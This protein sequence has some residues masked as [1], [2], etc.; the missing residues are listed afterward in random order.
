MN[1]PTTLLISCAILTAVM[2]GSGEPS[3]SAPTTAGTMPKFEDYPVTERLTAKPAEPIFASPET[4]RYLTR[5][6]NGVSTGVGVWNGSWKDPIIKTSGP[7]FAGHYFV[8]RWGCGAECVTMAIVDAKTGRVYQPPLAENG[9]LELKLDH[10]SDMEVDFRL[11]SSLMVL[12]NGCRDFAKRETCGRY[13]FD[14]RD[15]RFVLLK[16]VRLDTTKAPR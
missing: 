10:L 2:N 4:R 9:R 6:R 15:D 7:N 5:I 12:R 11:D 8:I 1:A 14:W 3:Q 16:F 13:Y